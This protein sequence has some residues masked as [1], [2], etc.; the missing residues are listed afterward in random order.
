MAAPYIPNKDANFN[1]WA[2][3]F[4]TLIALAPTV[5][6]L[7]AG[8]AA[9]ISAAQSD[10]ATAY[11]LATNPGTRTKATVAA[12]DAQRAASTAVFRPYA[13]LIRN[14]AGVTNENK[15]ALGLTIPDATPSPV[16]P[17]ATAPQLSLVMATPLA[18][19]LNFRDSVSPLLK[20]KPVGVVA[21][22]LWA[23]IGTVAAT[24]PDQASFVA[25]V[26]KTPFTN[27]FDAGSQGKHCTYFGR[28][29]TRSGAGG[30]AYAGPWSAPLDVMV[31]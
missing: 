13:I 10:W 5:Y 18:H 25:N 2:L 7:V 16:P 27:T 26:T 1:S 15:A 11:E 23:S 12:K 17:P 20:R 8:D 31:I 22:Q 29:V 19:Q 3:N 4:A 14:N 28:W 9:A 6:G 21:L 30:I 24:D